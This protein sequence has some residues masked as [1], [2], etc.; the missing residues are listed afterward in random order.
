VVSGWVEG[1]DLG[2]TEV[3]AAGVWEDLERIVMAGGVPLAPEVRSCYRLRFPAAPLF[4]ADME[5]VRLD[6]ERLVRDT[7]AAAALGDFAVVEGVGGLRVPL[8]PGYDT[9]HLARDLGW[10]AL[11]VVGIR[12]GCINH[13][14]LTAEV[15]AARGIPLAGWVANVG[16]DR[17]YAHVDETIAA[18]AEGIGQPCGARL[19]SFA[20][21]RPLT[22]GERI[23][24]WRVQAELQIAA[25]GMALDRLAC[26]LVA[27]DDAPL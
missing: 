25:A 15:L 4:A 13:A 12:L 16:L 11:L 22:A 24:D 20:G 27:K 18:I 3:H 5:Q 26:S 19:G 14:L 10:P 2:Q 1:V 21:G 23:E 6:P 7:L 9:S 17:N 8:V